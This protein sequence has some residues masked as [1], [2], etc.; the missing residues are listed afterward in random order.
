[1]NTSTMK[2][3]HSYLTFGGNCRQAM[4][5]YQSCL[6][7]A[8][9]LQYVGDTPQAANMPAKMKKCILQAVLKTDTLM[10]FG[11]DMVYESGLLKGN[12]ISLLLNCRTENEIRD[13]YN[14]LARSGRQTHPL[15]QTS[16]GA[17]SG[18][19]IDKFGNYW[20]FAYEKTRKKN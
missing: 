17:I 3:I 11:S 5:F 1:M 8:L 13:Y 19:L 15:K 16:A 12:N 7:G 10:L 20:L 6:G 14:K 2:S 9:S 4:K 18:G